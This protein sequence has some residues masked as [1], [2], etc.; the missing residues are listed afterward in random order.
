MPDRKSDGR[1]NNGGRREG[2]GRPPGPAVPSKYKMLRD[3]A[4]TYTEEA[5]ETIVTLMRETKDER[6]RLACA[7]AILDRGHG[8]PRDHIAVEQQEVLRASYPTL[9]EVK[10]DLIAHGLPIDHLLN[11]PK[12]IEPDPKR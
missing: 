10:A 5:F 1:R 7:N 4:R 9:E 3:L 8:K 2:A 11:M 12:L 6:L